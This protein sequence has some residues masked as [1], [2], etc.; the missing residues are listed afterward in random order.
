M[1]YTIPLQPV[2][3]Q[4]LTCTL[5]G[6]SC[7]F[8]VRQL[9]T[10]LYVDVRVDDQP[11]IIGAV[12]FNGLDLIRNPVSPLPGRLFFTDTQGTDDPYYDNLGSRFI[13]Q[14]DDGAA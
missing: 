3:A 1:I 13:L 5:S 7:S 2:P 10:G 6:R 9:S 14:Y 4:Q 8:W 12:G 11:A